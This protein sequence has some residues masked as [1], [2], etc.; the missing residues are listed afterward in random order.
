MKISRNYLF[1]PVLLASF[2]YLFYSAYNDV[3]E[4]TLD[5]FNSHQ[6]VLARQAS[7]GIESFF[8]YY[9]RELQF[10]SR[11]Q[12]VSELNDQGREL[13][14]EFYNNHS[15]QIEA[16]SV[17]DSKGVL[18]Y[19]F[20]L[21]L[22]ATGQDISDQAHVKSVI[23]T[24]KPTVSDVFTS[25][26][27][28]KTIAYHVPI[29]KDNE[30]MGS[31]AILIPLDKLGARFV[32]NIKTGET[33]YGWMISEDGIELFNPLDNHSG[34]SV[35]STY[36]S[37]PFVL[38]LINR[39]LL[40]TEG[41]SICY[42]SQTENKNKEP[43]KT[44]AAFYRIPLD[45]TF[46]TI[47]I[48][49]PEKEVYSTLKSFQNRLFIIFFLFI[50]MMITYYF[51]SFKASSILKEEKKRKALEVILRD[52][53]RRF[54]IMFE[55]SPAGIILINE[56]GTIIEVN[57]SFCETIGYSREEIILKN[58]S[59]FTSPDKEGDVERNMT[60]VLSGE[61]LKHE[62]TNFRKDG[63]KC[64]IALYET[65]IVLPDGQPGI[66]S[67][68]NDI[69]EKRRV[70]LELISAKEKAEESDK[71]KSTFLASISHELRTPLNAIIGF[72]NLI[73]EYSKDEDTVTNSKI[74]LNSGQHLL[75]LVED[76]FDTT[77]I[78]TGQIKIINEIIDIIP[79]LKE[80]RNIIYGESLR[81]NKTGI[82][83]ILNID[84]AINKK[85]LLTDSR[86]LKQALINLL[87]NAVKFTQEGYI[88][89]GYTEID[90]DDKKYLQFY[91]KD[92][93]IGI[94]IKYHDVIFNIFRQIDNSNTRKYGG[95]GIGLSIAKKIVNML[96]GEI[97][98]ESDPGKGS[99]FFFTIPSL[100]EEEQKEFVTLNLETENNFTGKTILIAED[101]AL[102]FEFLRL[103][104]KNMNIRVLWA[105]NGNEVINHCENDPSINLVLMDL[106]MPQLNGFEATR[107]LKK[108]RPELPV[109]AQT[110]YATMADKEEALKSG[111]NEY[112][113]KPLQILQLK[114]LINK[115][116]SPN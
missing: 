112:L 57:S 12:Y 46:W 71:L 107:R 34:Q 68:S 64:V 43:V 77:M 103:V 1:V 110:A 58:I 24:H 3:R 83:I 48:F 35:Y 30:Y 88:E 63:S 86:R 40:E 14:A 33:G 21:N 70:Q 20:P 10:L 95:T 28:Y 13:L 111:C 15:D 75:S 76:V 94:D 55:L 42:F 92:T 102:S 38:E 99:V 114:N 44:L 16:I 39:S 7:R 105:K 108:I 37:F 82:E 26:Q 97:W 91:V 4:R 85:F 17:L 98:V 116:L 115:Y 53:E 101:D 60:R 23:E 50:T 61:T 2:S 90:K 54:R 89:F 67:V 87:R 9:Q 78:E 52:S 93:G 47:I 106:K 18:I 29:I 80:V 6:F 81:E 25:V 109:I 62:V 51:L 96:G 19:T 73:A 41:T 79:V 66:L 49:T 27:G 104:F 100:T 84:Q 11:L 72:S 113:S 69:T 56:K 59:L 65:M 5:E 8:I 45:N 32:E 31:I 74:I 22:S 36:K